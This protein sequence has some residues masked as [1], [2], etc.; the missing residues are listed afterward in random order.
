MNATIDT[1]IEEVVRRTVREALQE[2]VHTPAPD[3]PTTMSVREAAQ[4]LGVSIPA[5]Y[6]ITER[7][8]FDALIRVGR[9]K[10]ILTAK[11]HEWMNRETEA[12]N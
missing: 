5:M 11:L 6:D 12:K 10:I 7:A 4:T 2:L 3:R 9:K 1:A 8:N